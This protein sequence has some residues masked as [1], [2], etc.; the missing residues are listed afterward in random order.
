MEEFTSSL[1]FSIGVLLNIVLIL[2]MILYIYVGE[3]PYIYI[4]P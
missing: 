2:L 4:A 3:L 1:K